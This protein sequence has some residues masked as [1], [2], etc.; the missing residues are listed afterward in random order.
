MNQLGCAKSNNCLS[1]RHS[2]GDLIRGEQVTPP[3]FKIDTK[4]VFF[5]RSQRLPSII[6][7]IHVSFREFGCESH[8]KP[9][10]LRGLRA[11]YVEVLWR[12]VKKD[13]QD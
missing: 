11:H 7:G 1:K 6:L 5:L 3:Q 12:A 8:L 13:L 10:S 9:K 2:W 4:M